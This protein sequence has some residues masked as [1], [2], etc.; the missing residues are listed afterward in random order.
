M[1]DLADADVDVS[2]FFAGEL[3]LGRAFLS[4]DVRKR[5]SGRGAS[6]FAG[7]RLR[8]FGEAVES[9]DDPLDDEE[10]EDSFFPARRA[11]DLRDAVPRGEK[12]L[13]DEDII[14]CG[15]SCS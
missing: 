4:G 14:N 12:L 2:L 3:D 15:V 6:F 1:P 9:D 10:E 7:V 11:V 5:S 8:R 13:S